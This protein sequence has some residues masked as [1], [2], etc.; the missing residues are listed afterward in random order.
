MIKSNNKLKSLKKMKDSNGMNDNDQKE[1]IN[2]D[3]CYEKMR[4]WYTADKNDRKEKPIQK[5]CARS[6]DS[7]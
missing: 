4:E 6:I 5:R 2:N 7:K 1:I 3:L